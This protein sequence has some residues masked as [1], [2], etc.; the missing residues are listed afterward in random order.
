MDSRRMVPRRM[1][2]TV[3]FTYEEPGLQKRKVGVR[4]GGRC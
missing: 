2:T 3:N 4:H 1:S